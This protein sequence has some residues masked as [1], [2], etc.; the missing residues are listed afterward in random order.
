MLGFALTSSLASYT[1][2]DNSASPAGRAH[3]D[4]DI[5][6][7]TTI[8]SLAIALFLGRPFGAAITLLLRMIG[9]SAKLIPELET[10]K[11]SCKDSV[12]DRLSDHD[13]VA[14]NCL[15]LWR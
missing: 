10:D 3:S 1:G 9:Y 6:P 13:L 11:A 15:G 4:I 8:G 7:L 14:T 5:E 12:D 2:A